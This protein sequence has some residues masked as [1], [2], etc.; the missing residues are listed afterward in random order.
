MAQRR[1][2]SDADR[3]LLVVWFREGVP[4]LEITTQLAATETVSQTLQNC[5]I[6][7]ET[8]EKA[9]RSGRSI[10]TNVQR[11]RYVALMIF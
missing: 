10:I 2:H 5:Y 3:W 6:I 8:V 1:R 7:N 9:R 11:Y 4:V